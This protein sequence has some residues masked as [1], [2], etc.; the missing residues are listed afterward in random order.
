MLLAVGTVRTPLL[1]IEAAVA[2]ILL[3]VLVVFLLN[4]I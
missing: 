1:M 3:E 4:V 2:M